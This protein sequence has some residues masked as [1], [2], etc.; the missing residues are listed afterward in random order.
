MGSSFVT[1]DGTTGFWMRDP[2]LELWLRLLALHVP[3]QTSSVGCSI[4]DKWLLASEF[5]FIGCVPHGLEEAAS[6]EHGRRIVRAAVESLLTQLR[7][8]PAIL[9]GGTLSLL[10][11]DC[12]YGDIETALLTEVGQAFLDL[13]DGKIRCTAESTKFMPGFR[14]G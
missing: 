7:D 10:G 1:I 9:D 6:T 2:T 5:S 8:A 14:K 13:L 12:G 4:R 11:F 3:T